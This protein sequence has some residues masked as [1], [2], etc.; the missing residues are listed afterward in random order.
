[1]MHSIFPV[2]CTLKS[3]PYNG[4]EERAVS[5][6]S[7]GRLEKKVFVFLKDRERHGQQ[8]KRKVSPPILDA[9]RYRHTKH[10]VR[11]TRN[12]TKSFYRVMKDAA[13]EK[14]SSRIKT[15]LQDSSKSH[16]IYPR[17]Q[18]ENWIFIT[19]HERFSNAMMQNQSTGQ[20]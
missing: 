8:W 3:L 14:R 7:T 19:C 13:A 1:M 9:T 4:R 18:I 10:T 12:Q 15:M 6:I 11:L 16:K 2:E 17:A 20:Q 5:S